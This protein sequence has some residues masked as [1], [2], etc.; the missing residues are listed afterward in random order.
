MNVKRLLVAVLACGITFTASAGEI[1]VAPAKGGGEII[2]T[3]NKPS[4]CD[5]MFFMYAIN[6]KQQPT[7]GCWTILDDM[8]HVRYNDGMRRVYDMEGWERRET[9][10]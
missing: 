3:L 5:G 6:K 2:L 7:Y 8:I 1:F 9:T 4:S 10:Q